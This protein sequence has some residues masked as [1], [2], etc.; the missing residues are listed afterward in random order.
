MLDLR[1]VDPSLVRTA[2]IV[3]AAIDVCLLSRS[4][5]GRT[6]LMPAD[7]PAAAEA[8]V[9]NSLHYHTEAVWQRNLELIARLLD[10]AHWHRLEIGSDPDDLLHAIAS[11]PE[12]LA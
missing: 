2:A 6:R 11:L 1:G 4:A 12:A 9:L 10:G 5:D 7:R 8:T 3:P